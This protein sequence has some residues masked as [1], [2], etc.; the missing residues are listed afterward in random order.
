M[1]E[2]DALLLQSDILFYGGLVV[3]VLIAFLAIAA[4][5]AR[6]YRNAFLAERKVSIALRRYLTPPPSNIISF[7]KKSAGIKK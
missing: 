3:V 5:D 2:I 4:A 1:T 7:N 6:H